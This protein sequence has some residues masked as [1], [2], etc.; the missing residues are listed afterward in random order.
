VGRVTAAVERRERQL[1]RRALDNAMLRE[2]HRRY[3]EGLWRYMLGG[4][5]ATMIT[6]PVVYSLLLPF[7]VLD[8]WVSAFEAICFRAWRIRRVKRRDYIAI[9]RHR[10]SYLNGLE[11]ANCMYCSYVN[12]LLAYVREVAARTEEH[13]CPIRHARRVRGAHSHY[14][15]FAAYGD[16]A[17]YRT[18]IPSLR[19][20]ARR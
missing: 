14:A 3:R 7:V 1:R 16:A 4:S 5:V 20:R 17:G 13:W 12:G 9:D 15:G 8:G 6:A 2:Y 19:A 10:L 18:A 11:K